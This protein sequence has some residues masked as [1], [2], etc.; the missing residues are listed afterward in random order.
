MKS[1]IETLDILLDEPKQWDVYS[2]ATDLYNELEEA[3]LKVQ[4]LMHQ[5][6]RFRQKMCLDL[7]Y[8]LRKVNPSFNISVDRNGCRIGYRRKSLHFK[9]E[10]AKG[11]WSVMSNDTAFANLFRKKHKP[12]LLI[13]HNIED[14]VDTIY[15]FFKENYKSL[16]EEAIDDGVILIDGKLSTL[17]TLADLHNRC[18]ID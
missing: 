5:M 11:I 12:A 6:H 18:M 15:K 7:S 10:I 1:I 2:Q 9:P 13:S 16:Q 4:N 14:F 17:A 8:R 3:K